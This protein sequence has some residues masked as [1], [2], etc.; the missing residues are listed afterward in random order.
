MWSHFD[1]WCNTYIFP[2]IH[3]VSR[4]AVWNPVLYIS[5]QFPSSFQ[6]MFIVMTRCEHMKTF[7]EFIQ[8]I[9]S[10]TSVLCV[11]F[12]QTTQGVQVNCFRTLE[13]LVLGYQHPHKGLV[14]P[15]LY[16]VPR[17]TDT[18]EESSGGPSSCYHHKSPNSSIHIPMDYIWLCIWA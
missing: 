11:F 9:Y 12:S 8:Y 14:T 6:F 1:N 5:W 13:D 16:G 2:L 15:L 18:G 17:D 7:M 10:V 3:W 4:E